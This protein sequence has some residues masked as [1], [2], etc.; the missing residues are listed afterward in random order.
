MIALRKTINMHGIRKRTPMPKAPALNTR[1]LSAGHFLDRK[2]MT[3]AVFHIESPEEA[4]GGTVALS[5]E[6]SSP[7]GS[8]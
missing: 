7:S 2:S 3:P 8:A 1:A 6:A 5:H 4:F